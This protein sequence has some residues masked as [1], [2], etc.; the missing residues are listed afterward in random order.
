MGPERIEKLLKKYWEGKTTLEEEKTIQLFFQNEAIPEH[1]E[2]VKPLFN[3]YHH[4]AVKEPLGQD[5]DAELMNRLNA[6]ESRFGHSWRFALKIAAS[7]LLIALAAYYFR[8][9]NNQSQKEAIATVT[10]EDPELAYQQT[11]TALLMISE[12]LNAGQKYTSEFK[13][14]GEAK[15]LFKNY[16]N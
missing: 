10:Y 14:L 8:F 2:S 4:E 16:E 7:V 12:K 1:L 15:S 11:K 5:F 3:Y 13:R 9:I 6:G